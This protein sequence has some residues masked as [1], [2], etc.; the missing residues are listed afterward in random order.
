MS[1]LEDEFTAE[2]IGAARECAKFAYYPQRFLQMIEERGGVATARKLV[3]SGDIQKGLMR[4]KR[5][6][7]LDLSMEAIML[8]PK[9]RPLFTNEER[10][11]A[12]W[13]LDEVQKAQ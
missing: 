4:L 10:K 8:K 13:R 11:A 3:L 7:R 9:Y 2:L 5:E 6:G 12:Q 1:I